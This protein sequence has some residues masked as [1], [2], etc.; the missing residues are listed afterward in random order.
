MKPKRSIPI[1]R[2]ICESK[3]PG[4]SY[5]SR[6]PGLFLVITPKGTASFFVKFWNRVSK[7]QDQKLIGRYHPDQL[8]VEM[9]RAKARMIQGRAG[10]GEDVTKTER[11]KKARAANQAMTVSQLIDAHVEAIQVEVEGPPG[12]FHPVVETWEHYSGFYDRFLRPKLGHMTAS[13]LTND[14]IQALLDEIGAGLIERTNKAG[15]C[16]G[17]YKGSKANVRAAREKFGSLFKW[18]AEAGRRYVTVNPCAGLRKLEPRGERKRVLNVDEIRQFWHGLDR[19]DL[20]VPRSIALAL[21]L[22]LVTMLRSREFLTAET[23]E[24][25]GRATR[26]AHIQVP[27]QRVKKRRV[28]IQP[29]SSL[30]Q[31]IVAE[32]I[33]DRD[34]A[35]I[36]ESARGL[37]LGHDALSVAL[38][39]RHTT[40]DGKPFKEIGLCEF[41]GIAKFTPH[42]LRH[43]A[44]SLARELKCSRADIASCLDHQGKGEDDVGAVTG[45]YIRE[46]I[47]PY[48]SNDLESKREVLETLAEGLLEIIGEKP[49]ELER[50]V[51]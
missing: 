7:K 3:K 28:I 31:T 35:F 30:A 41:L 48:W 43:T 6:C 15:I 17:Y 16:V 12:Y 50:L 2:A 51:A 36:F 11:R 42:D 4:R 22:E 39:G 29:L 45:V 19:P 13:E 1:T 34:Q 10:A 49:A 18:A 9:A 14:D 46:E 8:T 24:L 5:D 27:L 23:A 38:R 33:K 32:A 44:A 26:F 47:F 21:K 40:K 37:M 25:K 20:P